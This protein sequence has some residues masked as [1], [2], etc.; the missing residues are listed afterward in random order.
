MPAFLSALHRNVTNS[1]ISWNTLNYNM[2]ENKVGFLSKTVIC[3][4]VMAHFPK[5]L[6]FYFL[7]TPSSL[8]EKPP[9]FQGKP[10]YVLR[11]CEVMMVDEKRSFL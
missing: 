2:L 7:K 6:V 1:V 3:L 10:T 5:F 8:D 11:A 4:P 9:C